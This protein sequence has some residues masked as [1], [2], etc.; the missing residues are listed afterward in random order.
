MKTITGDIFKVDKTALFWKHMLAKT[1]LANE[2]NTV[3]Y[4]ET[5][6]EEKNKTIL[7]QRNSD[8]NFKLKPKVSKICKC[9]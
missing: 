6:I 5:P 9:S 4:Y 2:E 3:S 7:M 1:S 8:D